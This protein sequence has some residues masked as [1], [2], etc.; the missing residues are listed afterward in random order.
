MLVQYNR[1][2]DGER[3]D[4][5]TT[6]GLPINRARVTHFFSQDVLSLRIYNNLAR[7]WPQALKRGFDIVAGSLL[8]LLTGPLLAVVAWQVHKSG[9]P[10]LFGHERVGRHG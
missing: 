10:V 9:G 6:A 1:A 5:A 7:P 8:L 3:Y 4:T 2:R